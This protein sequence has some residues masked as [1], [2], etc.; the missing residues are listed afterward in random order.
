MSC[1][2]LA[3]IGDVHSRWTDFDIRY[4]NASDYDAL[5]F[6]GDL[7]RVVGGIREAHALAGLHKPAIVVPGNHDGVTLHQFLAELKHWPGVCERGASGQ[8]MRMDDYRKALGAVQLGGYSLHALELGGRRFDCLVGRPHSMGGNRLY[9]APYLRDRFGVCSLAESTA[10]L[11]RLVD[12]A[13]ENLIFLAHNGPAGLGTEADAPWGCDFR[14]EAGDFGDQDWREAIDYARRQGKRVWAV[15]G[16]HMHHHLKRSKRWRR[17]TV[18]LEGVRYVNAARV[19]RIFKHEGAVWHH[20]VEIIFS[21]AGVRCAEIQVAPE[22][23]MVKRL[24]VE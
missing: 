18:E 8:I 12:D 21:D 9:F 2:K 5:L 24:P 22:T 11:K 23:G 10:L 14:P 1:A 4:F 15:I 7:P 16:G 13:A 17:W 19:P 3:V 6:T 20:H